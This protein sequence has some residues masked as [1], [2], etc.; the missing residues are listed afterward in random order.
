MAFGLNAAPSIMRTIVEAT[1]SKDDAV[2][3]AASAYIN[4]VFIK[5]DIASATSMRQHLANFGR[6]SKEPEWLQNSARMLGL[7]VQEE[8]NMLI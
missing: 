5:E 2:Q 1:L 3:Q 4:D 7:T 8:G 6:T